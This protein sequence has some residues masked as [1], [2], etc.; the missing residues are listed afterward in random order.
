MRPNPILDAIIA[1]ETF[2]EMLAALTPRQ[3]AVVALRLDGLSFLAVEDMLG[4][5]RGCTY[6]RMK[7]PRHRLPKLFP[8]LTTM[9]RGDP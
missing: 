1:R 9:L 5:S 4:L 2:G 8:H 3:L 6:E 7:G